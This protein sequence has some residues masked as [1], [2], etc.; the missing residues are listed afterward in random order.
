MK[1]YNFTDGSTQQTDF[2]PCTAAA[3]ATAVNPTRSPGDDH[4]EMGFLPAD[5]FCGVMTGERGAWGTRARPVAVRREPTLNTRVADVLAQSI[6]LRTS[7][8][9]TAP[10]RPDPR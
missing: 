2:T 7:P 9:R 5:A 1:A 8:V 3:A 4:T 10:T 6:A